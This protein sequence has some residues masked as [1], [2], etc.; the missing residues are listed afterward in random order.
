MSQTPRKPQFHKC[1][2]GLQRSWYLRTQDGE[3]RGP[4]HESHIKDLL[5]YKNIPVE[6]ELSQDQEEWIFLLDH[7]QRSRFMGE[8]QL[9]K[10]HQK[11][12]KFEQ[13]SAPAINVRDILQDNLRH[14]QNRE[15]E[16]YRKARVTVW[17]NLLPTLIAY[18][19]FSGVVGTVVAYFAVLDPTQNHYIAG[20]VIGALAGVVFFFK[21]N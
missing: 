15:T 16:A 7:P 9:I 4:L 19:V 5:D 8:L 21:R 3:V 13:D 12:R 11:T 20:S 1:S 18:M 14:Q 17:I 10:L 2:E 6:I